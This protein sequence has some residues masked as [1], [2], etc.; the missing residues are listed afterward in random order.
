[1]SRLVLVRHSKP[2]I[3]PDKPASAWKLNEVGRRRS[4]LLAARLRDFSP[5]VVWS[6]EEPKAVETAETVAAAFAVPVR[7]A[8]GLEE[9]HRD[10]VPYFG[11]QAE[12]EAAVE[13]LFDKPDELV[14]GTETASQALRRFTAAIDRVMDAGQADNIVVT[15]G[16]VMTLY[17]ASVAGVEPVGLWRRLETPSYVV[18][19]LP[20]RDVHC[21]VESV[22]R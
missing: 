10:G 3:E 15:H 20:D 7:T 2:E 9:H 13:Q 12:F 5:A 21:V 6:S 14:L 4:E 19:G 17:A 22:T 16:T 8:D 11:T 18:L 1:M